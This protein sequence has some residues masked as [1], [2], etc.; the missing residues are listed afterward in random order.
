MELIFEFLCFIGKHCLITGV[1]CP[2]IFFDPNFHDI[3][4]QQFMYFLRYNRFNLPKLILKL[5]DSDFSCIFDSQKVLHSGRWWI[6]T[7]RWWRCFYGRSWFKL[8]HQFW[9]DCFLNIPPMFYFIL[10]FIYV[11]FVKLNI[12]CAISTSYGIIYFLFLLIMFIDFREH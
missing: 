10:L 2:R 8:K 1:G 3:N 11:C 7:L 9:V 6:H 5:L 12:K 4:R